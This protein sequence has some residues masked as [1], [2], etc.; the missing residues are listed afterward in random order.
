MSIA[1][2][3]SKLEKDFS[4]LKVLIEKQEKVVKKEVKK[5][6]KI[7]NV[8]SKS[9]LKK[10]SKSEIIEWIENNCDKDDIADFIWNLKNES[11]SESDN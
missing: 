11:E 7:E 4:N 10:F 8:T 9:Q 3:V 6:T 5:V 1:K 2:Y